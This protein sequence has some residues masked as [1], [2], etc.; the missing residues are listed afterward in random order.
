[1]GRGS[2]AN[3]LLAF[4]IALVLFLPVSAGYAAKSY[5]VGLE[6]SSSVTYAIDFYVIDDERGV[7]I[8]FN[9]FVVSVVRGGVVSSEPIFA[10]GVALS[11]ESVSRLV[12]SVITSAERGGSV[13]ETL[14]SFLLRDL[15]VYSAGGDTYSCRPETAVKVSGVW[16][17]RVGGASY[18]GYV[19]TSGGAIVSLY[20]VTQPIELRTPEGLASVRVE[21]SGIMVSSS[22]PL[23]GA[24]LIEGGV[25]IALVI[26][27]IAI[28]LGGLVAFL[29]R[30]RL[31]EEAFKAGGP[32]YPPAI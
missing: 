27:A 16:P 25:R 7:V 13:L 8:G 32:V 23:C 5:R 19:Y 31:L 20:I 24:P 12:S 14:P 10:S 29:R 30:G 18:T 21:A 17:L 15:I 28:T 1:M 6:M 2:V 22:Q 26:V 11:S 3:L 4:L 9:R